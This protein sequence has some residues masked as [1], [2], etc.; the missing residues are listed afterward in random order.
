MNVANV[1]FRRLRTLPGPHEQEDQRQACACGVLVVRGDSQGREGP[2]SPGPANCAIVS[3]PVPSAI[4]VS[5]AGTRRRPQSANG[6]SGVL[7]ASTGGTPLV[8]SSM[9]ELKTVKDITLESRHKMVRWQ[10][11]EQRHIWKWYLRPVSLNDRNKVLF[12]TRR[13]R[14][15]DL[16][17][18]SKPT[19]VV[20]GGGRGSVHA[21]GA[22]R[23]R[24][25]GK[26]RGVASSAGRR[27]PVHAGGRQSRTRARSWERARGATR[28]WRR[29]AK[30]ARAGARRRVVQRHGTGRGAGR[31][32]PHG[33]VV[34][35]RHGESPGASQRRGA[36]RRRI[37]TVWGI[38]AAH[39]VSPGSNAGRRKSARGVASRRGAS[40]GARRSWRHR[41]SLGGG[42]GNH[43]AVAAARGM[44]RRTG[45][46]QAAAR[47]VARRIT[48]ARG[49]AAAHRHGVG[50]RGGAPGVARQRRGA[51]PV[52]AGRRS[53]VAVA[54]DIARRMAAAWG[55][56]RR[57]P[58]CQAAAQGVASRRGASP[59]C[60]G[61]TGRRQSVTASPGCRGSTGCRQA[62]TASPGGGTGRRSGGTARRCTATAQG[63][64]EWVAG[65]QSVARGIARR[66]AAAQGDTRWRHGASQQRHCAGAPRR[67]RAAAHGVTGQQCMALALRERCRAGARGVAG[68]R[69]RCA[70]GA[71][72][73]A[74]GSGGAGWRDRDVTHVTRLI[75]RKQHRKQNATYSTGST[76]TV[77]Q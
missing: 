31:R 20:H 17:W 15:N 26:A 40:P 22:A 49:I 32:N 45:H 7:A 3:P 66:I 11:E 2:Q 8:A 74:R 59:S 6:A 25:D 5:P 9:E 28:V 67:R 35:R 63:G 41:V 37:A 51:S 12:V 36:S 48:A 23:A 52:G 39:G 43:Q 16:T 10:H 24:A 34:R 57:S 62:G 77:H 1:R 29:V 42:R 54:R 70:D 44:A 14:T 53:A 69:W 56:A 58:R 72:A 68:Q 21:R 38:V 50:D 61:G 46:R 18:A 65:R 27:N 64:G 75:N 13:V 19:R 33:G 47:G 71:K 55:D 73:G 30:P 60:R 76:I 4:D